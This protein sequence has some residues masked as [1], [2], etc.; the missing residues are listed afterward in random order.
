MVRREGD[1]KISKQ[2]KGAWK[3]NGSSATEPK[4]MFQAMRKTRENLATT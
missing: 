4:H 2:R 1:G 3:K